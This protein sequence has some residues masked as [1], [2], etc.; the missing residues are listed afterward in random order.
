MFLISNNPCLIPIFYIYPLCIIIL[1]LPGAG[2]FIRGKDLFWLMVLEVQGTRVT[3]DDTLVDTIPGQYGMSHGKRQG[4]WVVFMPFLIKPPVFNHAGA[5]WMMLSR[6]NQ[7]PKTQTLNI[8]VRLSFQ[9]VI[10]SEDSISTNES[11]ED[12]QTIIKP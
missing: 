2:Y 6:F 7:L 9:S 10:Y 8:I 11:L 1:K 4:A 12:V 3:V 5:P